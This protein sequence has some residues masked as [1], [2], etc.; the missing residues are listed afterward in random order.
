MGS[1]ILELKNRVKKP[2]YR[3]WSHKT[4]LSQIV[5]LQ[6]IFRNSKTLEWK[7]E[8]KKT[9]LYNSEILLNI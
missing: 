3:L 1:G 8:N 2:S 9:E 4:K 6:L 5:T 7:N